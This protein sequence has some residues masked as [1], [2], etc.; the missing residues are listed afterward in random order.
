MGYTDFLPLRP[1]RSALSNIR[2]PQPH[3]IL[4]E[5]RNTEQAQEKVNT[6]GNTAQLS[7]LGL[8][9]LKS[10]NFLSPYSKNQKGR[11]HYHEEKHSLSVSTHSSRISE[12]PH[13]CIDLRTAQNTNIILR[14][15]LWHPTAYMTWNCATLGRK[16][17]GKKL[18]I[19]LWQPDNTIN[20]IT[21]QALLQYIW[22][23]TNI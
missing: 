8:K 16:S 23:F 6:V 1:V 3:S 10:F 9:L 2:D 4:A 7:F 18:V 20:R 22:N 14:S 15:N 19:I 11:Q 17:G 21:S 5:V 12:P 13:Q